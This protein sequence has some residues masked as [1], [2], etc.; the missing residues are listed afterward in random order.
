MAPSITKLGA[1]MIRTFVVSW[2]VE[3]KPDC[4]PL[5]GAGELGYSSSV[6]TGKGRGFVTVGK[7]VDGVWSWSL[8]RAFG[9]DLGE[10]LYCLVNWLEIRPKFRG[11]E[12]LEPFI[13][14]G[15]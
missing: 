3:V 7:P 13:N 14:Q 5:G 4:P 2:A 12:A 11:Q 10:I 15:F 9:A 8:R 6:G 1:E